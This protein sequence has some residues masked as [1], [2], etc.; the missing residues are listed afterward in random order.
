M[1]FEN[2]D[3][4]ISQIGKY[5]SVEYLGKGTFGEV[6][7]SGNEQNNRCAVKVFDKTRPEIQIYMDDYFDN[8]VAMHKSLANIPNVI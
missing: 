1:A 2:K 8:E 3:E 7:A 5:R 6:Y 4:E